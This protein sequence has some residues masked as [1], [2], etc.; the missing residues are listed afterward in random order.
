MWRE[1]A[2]SDVIQVGSP[3]PDDETRRRRRLVAAASL[4]A[5][6]VATA[7]VVA[8]VRSTPPPST[9]P[10]HLGPSPPAGRR[11]SSS[12]T[13]APFPAVPVADLQANGALFGFGGGGV[14]H[15]PDLHVPQL[16]PDSSPTWSP[17]GSE[18]AVLDGGWI[19]VT[20]VATGASHRVACPSCREISWS[21]DGRVF[22][23]A[24]VENGALGLV[25]AVTGELTTFPAPQAGAVLSLTWAPDSTQLAFL[26]N[27]GQ[28]HS[29][30]YTIGADGTHLAEVLGLHAPFPQGRSRGTQVIVVRWSPTG[31]Q[32]VVLTATPDPPRGPPPI[33]RYRL[34]VVTMNPDGS[35]LRSLV[36]DGHCACSGFSPDLAWSPDGTTLAV[37]AQHHRPGLVK[38]DGVGHRLRIRFVVARQG[39]ALT[40]QPLPG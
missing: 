20:H 25:D 13:R 37:L 7:T 26:A 40:W 27:A 34:R 29:G 10:G 8:L 33:S 14:V 3:P 36:G 23:A 2:D 35:A 31:G 11:V 16:T 30:V 9:G 21:P 1:D 32:L 6:L 39:D 12:T 15:V 24:P 19:R 28:G 38:P 4:A 18:I 22:A 17:D 5:V